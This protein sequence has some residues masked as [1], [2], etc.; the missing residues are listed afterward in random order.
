ML[1]VALIYSTYC[2]SGSE[3]KSPKGRE[4][5]PPPCI[6]VSPGW[7]CSTQRS[8]S[9]VRTSVHERTQARTSRSQNV[10]HLFHSKMGW[11]GWGWRWGRKGDGQW[12]QQ[13]WAR[14]GASHP[15]HSESFVKPYILGTTLQCHLHCHLHL[16]ILCTQTQPMSAWWVA[17]VLLIFS[18][19][20][21]VTLPK[22]DGSACH[23]YRTWSHSFQSFSLEDVTKRNLIFSFWKTDFYTSLWHRFLKEGD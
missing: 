8:A 17:D 20:P 2:P 9:K 7:I 5:P 22:R 3:G 12:L 18:S 6:V 4:L 16:P 15:L 10:Q 23:W 11:K 19:S 14:K 13:C 21:Q 1:S